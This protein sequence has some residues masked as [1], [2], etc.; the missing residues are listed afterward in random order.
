MDD[1]RDRANDEV[2]MM[3]EEQEQIVVDSVK[4]FMGESEK[5]EGTYTPPIQNGGCG[6]IPA[7]GDMPE[8]KFN[9]KNLLDAI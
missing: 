7:V 5:F 4:S 1:E 9:T 6:T 2:M 8:Y 3:T